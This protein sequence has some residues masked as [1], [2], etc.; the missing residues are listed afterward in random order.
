MC[1][2]KDKN[3]CIEEFEAD[4]ILGLTHD[5]MFVMSCKINGDKGFLNLTHEQ[6]K[7]IDLF[8]G[9]NKKLYMYGHRSHRGWKVDG[10]LPIN[11]G[12]YKI[13]KIHTMQNKVKEFNE[14][15]VTARNIMECYE[16]Y[17]FSTKVQE[18]LNHIMEHGYRVGDDLLHGCGINVIAKVIERMSDIIVNVKG[19]E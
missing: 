15:K 6:A 3:F 18:V 11:L 1:I 19:N 13:E 12:A 7:D 5:D 10:F 4:E 8:D 14:A 16:S 2:Y 17:K 9:Y